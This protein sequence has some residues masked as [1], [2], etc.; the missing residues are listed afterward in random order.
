MD[1]FKNL[2]DGELV[3]TSETMDVINP[4]NETIAGS[5]YKCSE[6]LANKALICAKNAFEIYKK[7][8]IC[9]REELIKTYKNKLLENKKDIIDLL[10]LETGK[11]LSSAEGEFNGLSDIFSYFIEEVKRK[12]SQVIPD[13]ENRYFNYI[14]Y[15]P[16]GVVVS[17]LAWNYPLANFV[18][19]LALVLATGNTCVIKPSE[20]TPLATAYMCEIFNEIGFPKGVLNCVLGTGEDLG[21]VLC[22]SKIPR[23]LTLVGSTATGVKI[24]GN[25]ATSIKRFSLELGGNAPVI[26]FD[27]ADVDLAASEI[28]SLKLSN[29]GQICVA[30]NRI[31]VHE[32]IYDEFIEKCKVLIRSYGYEDNNCDPSKVL[33]PVISEEALNRL[34][35]AI[36]D[37]KDK[38][39]KIILGGSREDRKGYYLEPALIENITEG[40]ELYSREIFGPIA[41]VAKFKDNDD[42]F[43]MANNTDAGLASYVYTKDISKILEAEERLDFGDMIINGAHFPL[44]LNHSGLKQSGYGS[45]QGSTALDNFYDIKRVSIK[46]KI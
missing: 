44:N 31:F 4:A 41:A 1:I 28:I 29:A 36:K 46:R 35:N 8:N 42:I 25:S 23:V 21:K 38:G 20:E 32:K 3:A 18:L 9:E 10:V 17:F 5:F 37:A 2:V 27:D 15:C 16:V 7:T 6:E 13:Y 33:M 26:V 12:Y 14:K 19:R 40:M 24:I 43:K 30:P 39:A 22:S 34:L 45:N 11:P